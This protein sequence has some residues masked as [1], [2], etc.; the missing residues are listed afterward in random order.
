MAKMIKES[1]ETIGCTMYN[2]GDR[3]SLHIALVL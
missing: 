1:T 3:R 2:V